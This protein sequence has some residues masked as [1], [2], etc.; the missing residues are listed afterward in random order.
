MA[1]SDTTKG[2][3]AGAHMQ[4]A[5]FLDPHTPYSEQKQRGPKQQLEEDLDSSDD[6]LVQAALNDFSSVLK[7]PAY[8]DFVTPIHSFSGEPR[9]EC[10]FCFRLRVRY[11]EAI[12]AY[13]QD[14]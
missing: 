7:P 13:S 12:L 3:T 2:P 1:E 10:R 5:D 6:E 11:L 14:S 4:H 8:N 9:K